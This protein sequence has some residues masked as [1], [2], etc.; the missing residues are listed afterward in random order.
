LRLD[1]TDTAAVR[2]AAGNAFGKLGRMDVVVN[3][4]GYGLFGAAEELT[5]EQILAQVNTKRF[6]SDGSTPE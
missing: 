4:A 1:V 3:S 5:D 2:R 6:A